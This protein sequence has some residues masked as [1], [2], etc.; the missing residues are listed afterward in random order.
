MIVCSGNIY[1]GCNIKTLD[2]SEKEHTVFTMMCR[3][4]GLIITD[5]N[6]KLRFEG[7]LYTDYGIYLN[8]KSSLHIVG[9]WVTN[10]FNKVAMGGTI[11]VD[12]VSSKVRSSLGSLHPT[13]GK[14]DPSRY[15]V[16]FSPTWAS[17]RAH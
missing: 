2:Q 8:G 16:S 9:N 3:K 7:S 14:Y 13:R 17:W 11:V 4:G 1:L 12:Y 6:L 10:E 15:H 5:P